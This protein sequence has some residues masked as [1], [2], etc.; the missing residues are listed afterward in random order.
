[1]TQKTCRA[2]KNSWT[3]KT[4]RVTHVCSRNKNHGGRHKCKCGAT[5]LVK[6]VYLLDSLGRKMLDRSGKPILLKG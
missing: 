3:S 1:M 5:W 4:T 6:K 2:R